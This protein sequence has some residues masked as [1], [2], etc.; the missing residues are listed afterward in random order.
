[1]GVIIASL[2]N[3]F[4]GSNALQFAISVIGVFVFTGGETATTHRPSRS[5]MLRRTGLACRVV[6]TVALPDF[7]NIFQ[8]LLGLT[9][10]RK[11]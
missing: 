3:L 7:I 8:L 10:K 11:G 1:M 2:V 6:R 5:S 4:I 9:G